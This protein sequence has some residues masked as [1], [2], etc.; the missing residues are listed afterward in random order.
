MPNAQN[1]PAAGQGV[2]RDDLPPIE[3]LLHRV[4]LEHL[5]YGVRVR[6]DDEDASQAEPEAGATGSAGAIPEQPPPEPPA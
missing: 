2:R 1:N 5:L 6:L 4:P 3:E